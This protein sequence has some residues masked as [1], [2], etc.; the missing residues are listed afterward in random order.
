METQYTNHTLQ[1]KALKLKKQRRRQILASLLGIAILA[2]G[3]V[4]VA[5]LFCRTNIPK[6]AT[7]H[8]LSSIILRSI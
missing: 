6:Q 5:C 1:E 8:K 7:M 2:W 3:I 4:E